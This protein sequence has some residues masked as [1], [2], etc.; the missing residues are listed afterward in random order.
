MGRRSRRNRRLR[1]EGNQNAK[2]KSTE[3]FRSYDFCSSQSASR[4]AECGM[5]LFNQEKTVKVS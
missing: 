5:R 3:K 4:V 1:L 2:V